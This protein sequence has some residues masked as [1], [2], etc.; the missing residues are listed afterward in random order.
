MGTGGSTDFSIY[1][2]EIDTDWV[3][4]LALPLPLS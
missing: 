3:E 2:Q 4:G 1:R